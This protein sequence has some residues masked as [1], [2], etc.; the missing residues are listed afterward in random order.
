[1]IV[2][3]D[4]FEIKTLIFNEQK[5]KYRAL[6][7]WFQTPQGMR[8][9]RA[10]ATEIDN[11][12]DL[13]TGKR[14]LQLG[15]CGDNLWLARMRYHSKWL[16][17]PDIKSVRTSCC[18]SL[19]A[20]PIERSSIDCVIAPM[21]L[22]AF[23]YD[24]NPIDE[25]DRILKPMG[26]VVFLGVNPFSFWGAALRFGGL[27]CFGESKGALISSFS[28]A[29]MMMQRGYTQCALTSFY[30]IP[31]VSNKALI[32]NLEFLNEVG[33]MI[34]PFPAGL[35]CYIGQKYQAIS[36]SIARSCIDNTRLAFNP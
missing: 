6:D 10:F 23:G 34:W 2:R 5:N 1:M 3:V 19:S 29:Q 11:V 28:L 26:Y 36:P 30:Y 4:I 25:I 35:Y 20:L 31:P 33:K 13:W 8:V 21:T 15:S 12:A 32:R 9:A 24:K 17:T 18:A 14:L 27:R 16:I 22:E 7:D